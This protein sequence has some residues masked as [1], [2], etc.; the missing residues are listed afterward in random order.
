M[1]DDAGLYDLWV[2]GPNGF[3]REFKGDLNRLRAGGS[4]SPE[5][6]VGY[7]ARRGDLYLQLRNEGRR[8]CRFTVQSNAAYAPP[9]VRRGRGHDHGRDD[10]GKDDR[11]H[12]GGPGHGRD[13]TWNLALKGGA[14][15]EMSWS[16]DGSGNWYD[17]VVTCDADAAFYRRFAGRIETG[18]PS[19]SDP[20]M[21]LVDRF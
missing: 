4:P 3:H 20:A 2:L 17:F 8:D 12:H 10:D 5:I 14:D 7:D 1:T 9:A 13:R 21:G 6:R 19:V 16:L 18:R 15:A 11:G